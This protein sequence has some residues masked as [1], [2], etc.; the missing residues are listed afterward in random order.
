MA[1]HSICFILAA[2][3]ALL[4]MGEWEHRP[5]VEAAPQ[6]S[7]SSSMSAPCPLVVDQFSE[8]PRQAAPEGPGMGT[9][10]TTTYD[11]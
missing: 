1:V 7:L 6:Y 5:P 11:M 10:G 8:E 9:A 3:T 4:N 2:V